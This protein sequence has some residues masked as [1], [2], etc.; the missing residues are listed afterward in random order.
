MSLHQATPYIG[1]V[2]GASA[3]GFQPTAGY[4]GSLTPEK[5][6]RP[7]RAKTLAPSLRHG[8]PL[9]VVAAIVV[10]VKAQRAAR[11]PE[12]ALTLEV[13]D[14]LAGIGLPGELRRLQGTDAACINLCRGTLQALAFERGTRGKKEVFRLPSEL[15][16]AA[17]QTRGAPPHS[18]VDPG[19]AQHT[20]HGHT[21]ARRRRRRRRSHQA[22]QSVA[23]GAGRSGAGQ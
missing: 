4:V 17:R 15:A 12:D 6:P 22:Q 10:Y 1:R 13:E 16:M 5:A 23:A 19:A 21:P 11:E 2:S 8:A 9:A 14:V 18:T 3:E 20:P 7:P